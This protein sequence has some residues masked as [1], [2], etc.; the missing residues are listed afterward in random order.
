MRRRSLAIPIALL[1]SLTLAAGVVAGGWATVAVTE[2]SVDPPAG[3]AT[4]VELE[5]LQHGQTAVSWPKLTVV[6]TNDSTGE[7]FSTQASA[8]GPTGHYVATLTF[9][10]EG[11]W[12]LS[13]ASA[14]LIME[15]TAGMQVAAAVAPVAAPAAPAAAAFDPLALGLGAVVVF[16][17]VAGAA[18]A[19]RGR[20]AGR[21]D[22][23]ASV[24]G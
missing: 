12:T 10:T 13:F 5:V 17:V 18:I 24:S 11:G 4:T 7:T 6:A 15:G 23:R 21:R 14:D 22:E 16:A 20:H 9:P 2:A 8:Q 3:A 1:G 19:I